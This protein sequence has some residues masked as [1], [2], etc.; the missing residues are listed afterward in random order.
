MNQCWCYQCNRYVIPTSDFHC[1]I[2]HEDYLEFEDDPNAIGQSTQTSQQQ[3]ERVQIPQA[4]VFQFGFPVNMMGNFNPFQIFNNVFQ[5]NNNFQ[6][7]LGTIFQNIVNRLPRMMGQPQNGNN[8]I[9]M[10]D[11][12]FGSEDQL[13]ALAERLFRLNEQ[14]LGSPPTDENYVNELKTS[15]YHQ[16][17]CIEDVCSICL[18]QFEEGTN[19]IILPCKHAFHPDCLSPWLKIHSECPS[20]RHKLPSKQ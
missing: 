3:Q 13:Q 8:G 9:Q 11:F 4:Q 17:D 1:P 16:G 19:I 15:E 5:G 2:C 7:Q 20:C 10:N 18:D 12:F 14:S 6:T